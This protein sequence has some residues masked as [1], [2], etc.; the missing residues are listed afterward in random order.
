[1]LAT[2]DDPHDARGRVQQ[3]TETRAN[4]LWTTLAG[5]LRE[6]LTETTLDTWFGQAH[7]R[8]YDGKHLVVDVPNEFTRDWI[9]GHFVD[10]VARAAGETSPGLV[11]SFAV[12]ERIQ[13]RPA[14]PED[15]PSPASQPAPVKG[16]PTSRE[17]P[18]VELN[19]KYT[20]DLFVIGSSN[21]F[22]HAAASAVTN[23]AKIPAQ[24]IVHREHR[25][26]GAHAV[27]VPTDRYRRRR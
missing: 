27:C 19:P 13:P 26:A 24:R 23:N 21:R 18:E 2:F 22:A 17:T 7:A 10:L 4:D 14:V 1:M 16:P 6:T 8:S 25:D 12:G 9:T 3:P 15:V 5:R 20:F 11:V